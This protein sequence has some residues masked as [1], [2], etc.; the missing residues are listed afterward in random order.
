MIMLRKDKYIYELKTNKIKQNKVEKVD[1]EQPAWVCSR[2]QAW[3]AE[4]S[5]SYC[6]QNTCVPDRW[7]NGAWFTVQH[8][9]LKQN[10]IAWGYGL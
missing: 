5:D 3:I 4:N 1:R 9:R 6:K 7:Q 8:D 2:N 10:S